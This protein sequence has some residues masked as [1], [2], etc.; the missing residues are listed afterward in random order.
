MSFSLVTPPLVEPISLDQAKARLRISETSQDAHIIHLIRVARQRIEA[1]TGQVLIEQTWLERRD[2][3]DAE[4]RL[5]AFGTQFKIMKPPLISIEA[6][7]GF[8]A[9]DVPTVWS[10][11]SYFVDTLSEP[12]RIS[13]RPNQVFPK[14]GRDVGGIEI[15]FVCGYGAGGDAV[16]PALIEAIGQLVEAMS[17]SGRRVGLPLSVQSLIAPWRRLSL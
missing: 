2:A 12:G 3:W 4:G 13:L 14:P 11:S 5:H 16:P 6:I 8:D 7:R 15:E 1:L 17:A 9:D 10:A